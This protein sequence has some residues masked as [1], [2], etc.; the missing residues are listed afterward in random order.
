MKSHTAVLFLLSC[1]FVLTAADARARK[2]AKH[3]TK[4][5][6]LADNIGAILSDPAVAR[7]HWG[8]SVLTASGQPVYSL[9]DGQ[10]FQPAS[11]TKLFTTAAAFALLPG[12][13]SP[14]A[15][16]VSTYVVPDGPPDAQGRVHGG[17][18]LVGQGDPSISGRLLPYSGKTER[19][20][21][22]LSALESLAD[23]VKA[24]GIRTVDGDIFGDDSYFPFEKYGTDWGWDDLQW[25]SGA[26]VSALTVNDNVVY[27]DILPGAKAGDPIATAWNP[28]VPYYALQ[29]TATTSPAGTKFQ[30][31][32][33]RPPG[34]RVI[35]LYGTLP[36]DSKGAHLAFAIEDPAEFAAIAFRQ[37]LADRGIHVGGAGKAFH[38]YSTDTSSYEEA[39]RQPL[40]LNLGLPA[41][42]ATDSATLLAS[43][44]E[45]PLSEDLTVTNKVSQNLHAELLLRRLGKSQG[46]D[47]SILDGSRVVRQFLI[48]AGVNGDDFMFY[49]GSGMSSEGIV[50]PRAITALLAYVDRQSWAAAFRATLPVA[51]VDGTLAGRFTHS[52]VKG[53]LLAK[54]GTLAEVN[55]LSGYLT[56]ASGR[57]VIVSIVVNDHRADSEAERAAM[58][59]IVEAIA[60]AE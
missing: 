52:P 19:P 42:A 59:R 40:T 20:N 35:R 10:Y 11:N 1:L 17:L 38:R 30:L 25:E 4:Q 15:P 21:P 8:I 7:A 9:N 50:T 26:P 46:M 39:V 57:T 54:T 60:R 37:M 24:K 51:G 47:G 55:A 29:G 16:G 48:N 53:R 3:Q 49:D 34:S 56:A 6:A 58:D 22:P 12:V 44:P 5:P 14:A 2:T 13:T 41:P 18:R 36:V 27:L 31:G 32:A 43:R 23:Q 28:P 33:D 45:A